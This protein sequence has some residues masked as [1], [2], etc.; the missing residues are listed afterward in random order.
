MELTVNR[1]TLQ[2]ITIDRQKMEKINRQ[3]RIKLGII[4]RQTSQIYSIKDYYSVK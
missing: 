3:P 1:Q 2:K 4:S